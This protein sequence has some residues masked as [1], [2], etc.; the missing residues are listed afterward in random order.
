MSLEA[1]RAKIEEDAAAEARAIREAAAAD[2]EA[3]K[4][5]ARARLAAEYERDSKRLD[6]EMADLESR[7]GFHASRG[8]EMEV[9]NVSRTVIDTAIDRAVERLA[10]LPDAE[11]GQLIGAILGNCGMEGTI[12]VL[13]SP[14]DESRLTQKFFDARSDMERRFVLSPERH[15]GRGGVILRS[16]RISLN[17]TFSTAA[18]LAHESLVM[19]LASL[20]PERG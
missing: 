7:L 12:E 9:E 2:L 4:A 1:I 3:A 11:Y 15:G 6:S 5:A 8:F 14:A 20:L 19:D 13:I 17:A 16:G 10:S 18:A